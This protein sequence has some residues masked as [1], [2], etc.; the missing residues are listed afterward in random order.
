[1]LRARLLLIALLLAPV[2]IDAAEP[3]PLR[4]NELQVIGSHN[5]YHVEPH[6]S[7]VELINGASGKAAEGLQYSHPPL[8]EQFLRL[9]IRQIELD[10]FCDPQGGHFAKPRG[11]ARLQAA[12]IAHPAWDPDGVMQRPGF[13]VL[14]VPDIDFVSTTPLLTD[15]LQALQQWSAA[16][17]AHVPMLVLLELKESAPAGDFTKP[18]AFTARDLDQLDEV[19][20][21]TIPAG[22]LLTPD[23]LRGEYPTLRAAIQAQGWPTLESVRGRLLFALDNENAVRD[24]YLKDHPALHGRV[25]LTSVPADHPA[26]GFMKLN[27]PEK[28]FDKIQQAVRDG[29]LVRTRAD[30]GTRQSRRN[31]GTLRDRALATGAQFV[32]TDYAEADPRWSDYSV[33]LPN[34]V[35]ARPNP[36]LRPDAPLADLDGVPRAER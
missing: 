20:R 34:R 35:I 9:G 32:S 31:D 21:Q 25:L 36:L 1:M 2:S 12:G 5:S 11:L 10:V 29:F 22:Q 13:K 17:A 16:H 33:S 8:A 15:A 4:M 6:A 24:L 26:A 19:I 27:D 14:H 28:D 3:A 7:M 23:S 30:V 18:L